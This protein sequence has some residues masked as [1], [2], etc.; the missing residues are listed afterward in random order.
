MSNIAAKVGEGPQRVETQGRIRPSLQLGQYTADHKAFETGRDV[1]VDLG[2]HRSLH[3]AVD[4]QETAMKAGYQAY[5]MREMQEAN[6]VPNQPV[7]APKPAKPAK[8]Q[9][10]RTCMRVSLVAQYQLFDCD[11]CRR[12]RLLTELLG[13]STDVSI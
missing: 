2:L 7:P 9:E 6:F 8:T 5:V 11:L 3:E 13:C 1:R 12:G 4:E 10:V